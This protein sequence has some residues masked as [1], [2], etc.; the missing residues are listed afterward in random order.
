MGSGPPGVLHLSINSD[1]FK[2]LVTTN[3]THLGGGVRALTA[4]LLDTS[5]NSQ[6]V[7]GDALKNLGPR[8]C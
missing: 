2:V 5:P 7:S 4:D 6:G 3:D 1:I 8:S